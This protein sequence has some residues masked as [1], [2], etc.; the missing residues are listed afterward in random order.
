M[1]ENQDLI[2]QLQY[3]NETKGLI[4]QAIINKGQSIS[5]SDTFRSYV[6]KINNISTGGGEDIEAELQ[7]QETLI[8]QLKDLV[9]SKIVGKVKLF[10]TVEAMQNDLAPS[11][12]DLAIVYGRPLAPVTE[13][14]VFSSCKFPNTVVLDEAYSGNTKYFYFDAADEGSY[15]S[16]YASLTSA[17]FQFSYYGE[18]SNITIRYSSSDGITYTRTDSETEI[19]VFDTSLTS[20]SYEPFD[21]MVSNF[22][23]VISFNFDGLYEYVENYTDKNLMYFPL[24]DGIQWTGAVTTTKFDTTAYDLTKLGEIYIDAMGMTSMPETRYLWFYLNTNKELC[25]IKRADNNSYMEAN[26]VFDSNHNFKG[27][28]VGASGVVVDAYKVTDIDNKQYTKIGSYTSVSNTGTNYRIDMPDASSKPMSMGNNSTTPLFFT[29]SPQY[30][31][32]SFWNVRNPDVYVVGDKYIRAKTQFDATKEFVYKKDFFGRNGADKG[33]MANTISTG[34]DDIANEIY[35]KAQQVYDNMT[36]RV[37]SDNETYANSKCYIFPHKSDGTLLINTSNVTKF[38]YM[39][40][41]CENLLVIPNIDTSNAT[42]MN[43]MFAG[44][45]NILTIPQLDTSNV[46]N[47][48]SLANNCT[49]MVS[50]PT[51]DTAKVT[52]FGWAFSN[53]SSLVDF[54]SLNTSACTD[55]TGMFNS[56]TSLSNASLNNI[57]DMCRKAT[58]VASSKKKLSDVGLS[59]EQA[60]ICQ[61]L[62]NYSAFTSAGWTT[63][64]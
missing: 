22:M 37:L 55:M 9:R 14:S 17:L 48:Y 1:E 33:T 12:G 19:I 52:N 45:Y 32:T 63:G 46:T 35:A 25:F 58:G 4:K 10:D 28:T 5:P 27:F 21:D 16:G 26:M 53:C 13:T 39:F 15:S 36:P 44:C 49:S 38:N 64:Y 6:D 34:F 11:S 61:S 3:L 23:Y 51:I 29:Y 31:S 54:P 57:L 24:L 50:F 30:N 59:S 41:A 20:S 40:N 60:T 2:Q 8:Q 42:T 47:M 18:E 62:S 43:G 7:A 56:C